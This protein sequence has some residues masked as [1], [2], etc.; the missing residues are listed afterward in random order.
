MSTA[1]MED[2]RT[3]L[4]VVLPGTSV[5]ML[6]PGALEA[7][8]AEKRALRLS[9]YEIVEAGGL[10]KFTEAEWNELP[11]DAKRR[12]G[13][14]SQAEVQASV[15]A[16]ADKKIGAQAAIVAAKAAQ[17]AEF[18]KQAKAQELRNAQSLQSMRNDLAFLQAEQARLERQKADVQ[19]RAAAETSALQAQAVGASSG[20]A[21]P[22]D[23]G[24]QK[25]GRR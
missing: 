1:T 15:M 16:E 14:I 7:A 8:K 3:L 20:P 12:F 21:Q 24:G 13:Y 5:P 6:K 23:A 25:G 2:P 17:V 22:H 18:E 19:A 9:E 10:Y 11:E 4:R